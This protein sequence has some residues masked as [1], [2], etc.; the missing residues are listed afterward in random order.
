MLYITA[1][2]ISFLHDRSMYHI[3][4]VHMGIALAYYGLLRI[5]PRSPASD[6]TIR[7]LTPSFADSFVCANVCFHSIT[8]SIDRM[9]KASPA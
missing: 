5:P 6:A 3:D 2:A 9:E 8:Q 1:Q 7:K 4:A